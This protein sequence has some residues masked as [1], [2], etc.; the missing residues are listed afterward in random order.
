MSSDDMAQKKFGSAK[1]ISSDQFFDNQNADYETIA[2]L[3]RFQG[4]SSISSSDFFGN[5][6]GKFVFIYF[7]FFSSL[8]FQKMKEHQDLP[9]NHLIWMMFGK[10]SDKE[11]LKLLEN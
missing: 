8:L 5:G 3:N 4:S 6:R 1:A 2:N 7:V 10:A 9:F 11:L